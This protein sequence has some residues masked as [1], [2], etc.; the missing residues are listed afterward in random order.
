MKSSRLL[1]LYNQTANQKMNSVIRSLSD[2]EWNRE[3][4]G[5]FKTIKQLCGHIYISDF[6]WL[7]R[8]GGFREFQYFKDPLFDQ[9]LNYSSDP[10]SSIGDYLSKREQLDNKLI[11]LMNELTEADLEKNISFMNIKGEKISKNVGGSILHLFNHQTHHRGMISVYLDMMQM[12]N[13]FSSLL[14]LV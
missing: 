1:A 11:M 14:P 5:Y 10:F 2:G 3:F 4:S 6:G 7:K 13:D 12:E 9:A 8:F